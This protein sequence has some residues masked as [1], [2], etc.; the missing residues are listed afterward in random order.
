[1]QIYKKLPL[2]A[3]LLLAYNAGYADVQGEL[4]DQG[5]K[6]WSEN[7]T[8]EAETVFRQALSRA[9]DNA[10]LAQ[11]YLSTNR[12]HEAIPLFQN[13]ITLT[14]DDARLFAGLSLAYLHIQEYSKAAMMAEQANQLNPGLQQAQKL[15][16]YIRL[17][18]DVIAADYKMTSH[19]P[20]ATAVH[21]V[22]K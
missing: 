19:Q 18:Q 8:A 15:S 12:V 16:D 6:L 1:M 11:L 10:R 2:L 14:P 7:N 21:A 13:A 5:N 20:P 17:K 4:I 3:A 9:P 22:S